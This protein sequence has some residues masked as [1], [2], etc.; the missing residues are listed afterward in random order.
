MLSGY[1][2]L[3]PATCTRIRLDPEEKY[4]SGFMK[5]CTS[6]MN[7]PRHSST[8]RVLLMPR[9]NQYKPIHL[10]F[11]SSEL[12]KPRRRRIFIIGSAVT[13]VLVYRTTESS[14]IHSNTLIR[15]SMDLAK[16]LSVSSLKRVRA[17][18]GLVGTR[19]RNASF[20]EIAPFLLEIRERFPTMGARQMVT[21]LRHDYEL[22]VPEQRLLE[23]FRATEPEAINAQ[24][25]L[26]F[27]RKRFWAA[28]VMDIWAID[29][30]DKWQRFGLWMHC[31]IDPYP[32]RVAWL[33]IWW[34]NRNTRLINSYYIAAGRSVGGIP[35]ITQ[36][37][38]G[39]ENNGVANM[40]TSLRHRLD[41]S[42]SDTLQ[43]RWCI[44]K[45]N[46]KPEALWSQLRRQFTPGFEKRLD[47]GLNN[48]W[49]DPNNP[50]EKLLFRWLAIPWLQ[51][52]L[53]A[54]TLRYNSSSRRADKHKILP[55]GIPDLIHEKPGHSGSK[56]FMVVVSPEL[57]DE[58]KKEWAPP[59]DP[60][61]RLVPSTFDNQAS[62]LYAAI[63]HP[64]VS[65]STFWPVYQEMLDAFHALPRDPILAAA[66][67][68]AN[69]GEENDVPLMAGLR[70][71][72]HGDNVV[73][74]HGYIYYGGLEDP[75]LPPGA[76]F[77]GDD[78]GPEGG[79]AQDDDDD[80]LAVD[81]REYADFTHY[82][83][84]HHMSG[85]TT[86]YA[87]DFTGVDNNISW[88]NK[89]EAIIPKSQLSVLHA[90][91]YN[92]MSVPECHAHGKLS[93]RNSQTSFERTARTSRSAEGTNVVQAVGTSAY[94]APF[95][96]GYIIG[97]SNGPMRVG[98]PLIQLPGLTPPHAM[99]QMP[100][101]R[102]VQA[103]SSGYTSNHA[104]YYAT[105]QS[106]AQK[107]YATNGG[108]N[109]PH[110]GR[111][112]ARNLTME[113]ACL[114]WARVLLDLVYVFIEKCVST[115]GQPQFDIPQL[116]FVEAALAVEDADSSRESRVFLVEEVIGG[117]SEGSFR[118][119]MNNVSPVPLPLSDEADKE[120]AL[121]LAFSQHVQYFKT[122]KMAFI[123]DYQGGRLLSDP[124]IVTN[125]ALGVIFAD[126][127]VPSS[128]ENFEINHRCNHF[129][130]FFEDPTDYDVWESHASTLRPDIFT[131]GPRH[132]P[133]QSYLGPPPTGKKR[134]K[135]LTRSG[136]EF[137]PFQMS[138]V[139]APAFSLP[140][141][142]KLSLVEEDREDDV[143]SA[144]LPLNDHRTKSLTSQISHS[145][146]SNSTLLAP[147]PPGAAASAKR[148][149]SPSVDAD[150]GRCAASENTH[151]KNLL[152]GRH[153]N[154]RRN[155]NAR[156]HGKRQRRRDAAA[157]EQGHHVLQPAIAATHVD[158]AVPI[159]T[160]L[161]AAALPTTSCGYL[162]LNSLP[163]EGASFKSLQEALDAGCRLIEWDGMYV[164][165]LHSILHAIDCFLAP[166][167]RFW[168]ARVESLAA[169]SVNDPSYAESCRRAYEAIMEEGRRANFSDAEHNHRRGNFPAIN[170]GVTMAPGA[171]HPTN[172]GLGP[173][174][175]MAQRLLNNPDIMRIAHFADGAFNLWAP[176]IHQRYRNHLNPLFDRLPDLHKIFP[177]SI[178]PAAA[179][180]F[181]G[182]V[183]TKSHRDSKNAAI[184]W[185]GIQSLGPFDPKKG[186]HLVLPDLKIVI[187]F[188]PG[189]LI[190][191]PS[192]TLTHAN[193]PVQQGDSRVS[194]IQ[195]CGG[196]L[197]RFVDNGF[198]TEKQLMMNDPEE[199]RR[200]CQLKAGR[201]E[202]EVK[203][204]QKLENIVCKV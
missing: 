143:F 66:L 21:V 158:R 55:Q 100:T 191:I 92:K 133:P 46:I 132:Y 79:G 172:L 42:L 1:R 178:F 5:T 29:Q 134:S 74:Q 24:K 160:S 49:Y 147:P 176:N 32:G 159:T 204:Y 73:G 136:A 127:N 154:T 25:S 170:V 38:R 102:P 141:A 14:N 152:P 48:G 40:H 186:G 37:D 119:Y 93:E 64:T 203:L 199:Y 7:R 162:A 52:E 122:K 177:R 96:A 26:K 17:K 34:C 68:T 44:D 117:A 70:E 75:G 128:H 163:G 8:T 56:N 50:I 123:S 47:E 173:H 95:Q 58:I 60:V 131:Y 111:T 9:T 115:K 12:F 114:V 202:R 4:G 126:G 76:D 99:G 151:V 195:Y 103:G 107:A 161:K 174:K 165:I 106:L 97:T 98:G 31:S 189:S 2:E 87:A 183:W 194:F 27:R 125:S 188:P 41:P 120:R 153:C 121:F 179:I 137:S 18:L 110:D 81:L 51:A 53:D 57:F 39:R 167:C 80:G 104:A 16:S 124:Q 200:M 196:G 94:A 146:H 36:S 71:L 190:F 198:C 65:S 59:N 69:Y 168:T 45:K 67:L 105:R 171:A 54:W 185:C 169:A 82:W 109:I 35:L 157:K 91:G 20:E 90:E 192:A 72:R 15:R 144:R 63:G 201:W 61:F 112:Q 101:A 130:D 197:L 83:P 22:K 19:K 181:G 148:P 140:N 28:G 180:N 43:H 113:I 78:E 150:N 33:K 118:K 108:N 88:R 3:D 138:V 77:D 164:A 193:I 13:G 175:G 142:L 149:R 156:V 85:E 135:E 145:S 62:A 187:E 6:H 182:N 129:C 116:R 89:D 10:H 11:R 139:E 155:R 23:L 166:L 86:Q 84:R 30:H 184:G